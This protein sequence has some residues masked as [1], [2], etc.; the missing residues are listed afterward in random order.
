MDD[1][2]FFSKMRSKLKVVSRPNMVKN[3]EAYALAD[4]HQILA[5]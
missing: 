4:T 1:S 5:C 2:V 3:A